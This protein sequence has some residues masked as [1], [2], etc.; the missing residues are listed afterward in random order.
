MD[1]SKK[2]VK[3]PHTERL[4]PHTEECILYDPSHMNFILGNDMKFMTW[5]N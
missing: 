1:K 3:K 4:K 2:E 5:Q